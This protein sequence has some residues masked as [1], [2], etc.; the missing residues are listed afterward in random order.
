MDVAFTI[1]MQAA[2]ILQHA[3]FKNPAL[4]WNRPE[5]LSYREHLCYNRA[6]VKA[7]L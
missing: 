1:L 6:A 7:S 3:P 5:G 4:Q 2:D